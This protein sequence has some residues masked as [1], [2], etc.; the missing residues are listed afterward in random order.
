[1]LYHFLHL[2]AA[3]EDVQD[4]LQESN[5]RKRLLE[6]FLVLVALD[7]CSMLRFCTRRDATPV[8]SRLEPKASRLTLGCVEEKRFAVK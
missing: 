7:S 4:V 6:Q 2:W 5:D 8:R 3:L 1:M